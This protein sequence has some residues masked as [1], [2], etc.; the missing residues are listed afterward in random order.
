M[1]LFAIPFSGS[2]PAH[3]ALLESGLPHTVRW[4]DRQTKEVDD[5]RHY[6][7]LN[8][9]GSVPAIAL[10][11]GS[12]VAE[13]TAVL[14]YVG[15]VGAGELVPPAGTRARYEALEWLN[16]IT[17][18]L[19]KKHLWVIFSGRATEGMKTWARASIPSALAIAERHME[20]RAF[21][22]GDRF[23]VVDAYL[24]WAL[25]VAPHGGVPLDA[26]P[27]LVAYAARLRE[28]PAIARAMQIEA[29][30]YARIQ[31]AA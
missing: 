6:L 30:A 7:D 15:D 4:V 9:K 1:E 17:T 24:F 25:F 29:P 10:D 31:R 2:F 28:R 3:V 21:V 8:P 18:E 11:D 22:V 5:G 14:Q 23:T 13:S 12:V 26:F 27:A 19:H 20:E 16:W